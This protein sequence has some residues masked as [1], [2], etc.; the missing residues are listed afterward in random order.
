MKSLTGLKGDTRFSK[1]TIMSGTSMACP[2]V[3][4]VA[5]YVKSFHP[6]WS[7]AAI[8]SAIMT[9]GRELLPSNS[10]PLSYVSFLFPKVVLLAKA[11]P[12]SSQTNADA[13][14]AYG[15]GQIDPTRALSPGLVYDA[16]AM[17]YIQFLCHEGYRGSA[18]ANLVGQSAVNCSSLLPGLG[19]DALNYPTMQLTSASNQVTNT[20]TFF[21]TV[22]N[23]GPVPAVYNATIR[24]PKVVTITVSPKSLSFTSPS[25]K[26]SFKV[27]VRLRNVPKRQAVL[28]AALVWRSDRYFVR[29]PIVINNVNFGVSPSE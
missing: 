16:K 25:Q 23:V 5:A 11:K 9:T 6:T 17:S 8:R 24:A 4:G 12:M 10:M 1:F 13:E 15:V 20:A 28:S 19:Y 7:P 14:L 27:I 18:L 2:H 29:S 3:A 21:R 26:R 22:T